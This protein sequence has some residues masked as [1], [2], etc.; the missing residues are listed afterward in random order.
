MRSPRVLLVTTLLVACTVC[1]AA[2]CRRGATAQTS[3]AAPRPPLLV[4]I[5]RGRDDLHAVSMG[6]GL[7]RSAVQRGQPVTVFLNV[8]APQFAVANLGEDVRFADFPPVAVLVREILSAGGRVTVCG[9]CAAIGH[10]GQ[11]SFA[12]GVTVS[13][14]GDL[15]AALT[16]GTISLSY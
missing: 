11:A 7:A 13:E 2:G 9:H 1:S 8:A 12:K 16:P 10:I 6:L 3:S 4:N 14:H 15:L 5:T